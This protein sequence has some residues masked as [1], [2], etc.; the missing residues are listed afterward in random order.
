MIRSNSTWDYLPISAWINGALDSE[1]LSPMLGLQVDG[2]AKS[3]SSAILLDLGQVS[4]NVLTNATSLQYLLKNC[5]TVGGG[6]IGGKRITEAYDAFSSFTGP[7]GTKKATIY[8]Q[9]GCSIPQQRSPGS[10][11]ISIFIADLVF[12]QA[13]FKLLTLGTNYWGGWKDPSWD[14]CPGCKSL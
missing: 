9:Y 8:Q 6:D 13:L 3:F 11:V 7:L 14:H 2:F 10:L 4:P 12:L 1:T 5:T